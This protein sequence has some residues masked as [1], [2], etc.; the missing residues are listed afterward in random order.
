M[1]NAHPFHSNQNWRDHHAT[2][3]GSGFAV[4]DFRDFTRHRLFSTAVRKSYAAAAIINAREGSKRSDRTNQ[5]RRHE[6]LAGDADVEL[7]QRRHRTAP[8]CFAGNE[9]SERVDARSATK[10]GLQNAHLEAWGPFG[11]GWT[12]KRFSAQVSSR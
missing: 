1:L 9:A 8:D 2:T 7:S 11:R 6:P 10:W 3:Q 12:L 4:I 5:R